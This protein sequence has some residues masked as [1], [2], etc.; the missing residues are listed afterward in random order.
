MGRKIA[1]LAGTLWILWH[2]D[3]QIAPDG[4]LILRNW[5]AGSAFDTKAH[6]ETHR[7]LAQILPGYAICLPEGK[8]PTDLRPEKPQKK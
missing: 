3:L 8:K 7:Q 6:C 5:Q 4:S 1:L 2:A